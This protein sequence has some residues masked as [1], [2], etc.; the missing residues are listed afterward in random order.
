MY[1]ILEYQIVS[2]KCWLHIF[3]FF[4]HFLYFVE[5][6]EIFF[7]KNFCYISYPH[8]IHTM[9]G[10]YVEFR[11]HRHKHTRRLWLFVEYRKLYFTSFFYFAQLCFGW[12]F[13]WKYKIQRIFTNVGYITYNSNIHFYVFIHSVLIILLC[14]YVKHVLYRKIAEMEFCFCIFTKES[15]NNKIKVRTFEWLFIVNK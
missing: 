6:G 10:M 14:E 9:C 1:K 12:I 3:F 4:L 5:F 7:C 15:L 13:G 2:V 11:M 8:H